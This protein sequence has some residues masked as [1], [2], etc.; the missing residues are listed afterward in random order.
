LKLTTNPNLLVGIEK[1]DD[2][3]VYRL[4]DEI[5][6]VQTV[7]FF[8]PLVDDPFVYGQ[9]AAANAFSDIYAMGAKPLTAMNIT[10]FPASEMDLSI[11]TRV[12]EGGL[13]KIHEAEAVL[14]GGHSIDDPKMKYGLSVTGIVHPQKIWTNQGIQSG[15]RLILTKPL[16]T[17]IASTAV[18]ANLAVEGAL[19]QMI[20]SMTMLNKVAQEVLAQFDVHACTDITGFGLIGHAAEMINDSKFGLEIETPC[21]PLFDGIE[22]YCMQ[23][24]L[25]KGLE[26]NRTHR[27]KMVEFKDIPQYL[28]AVVCDPQTSGGLLVS[29]PQDQAESAIEKLHQVKITDATIIGKVVSKPS[30]KIVFV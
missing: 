26:R 23:G 29:L 18:K 25:P 4:S 5:A 11:L 27:E 9:I 24:F 3:G 30:G 28:Q 2:A 22:M 14:V 10:C 21:L 17:G 6:L 16:G 12:L 15:D 8:T 1:A 20:S 7:D 19:E 13:S